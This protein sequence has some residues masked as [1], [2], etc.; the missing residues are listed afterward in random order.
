MRSKGNCYSVLERDRFS[1]LPL[2][3]DPNHY[4]AFTM[5]KCLSSHLLLLYSQVEKKQLSTNKQKNLSKNYKTFKSQ[6]DCVLGLWSAMGQRERKQLKTLSVTHK[7]KRTFEIMFLFGG[8]KKWS[9]KRLNL[10]CI[11]KAWLHQL[12][13]EFSYPHTYFKGTSLKAW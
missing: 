11:L 4:E 2:S 6:V 1:P 12:T 10:Y 7:G 13:G 9:L 5:E 8:I 3:Y